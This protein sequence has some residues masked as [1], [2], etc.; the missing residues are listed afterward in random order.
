MQVHLRRKGDE[1]NFRAWLYR[2]AHN[3]AL[4]E[5]Q[6]A[7]HRLSDPLENAEGTSRAVDPAESPEQ[8]LLDKERSDRLRIAIGQ[9]PEVPRQCVVMR[10]QGLRFREIAEVLGLAL[11]TVAEHVQRGLQQVRETV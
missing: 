9:L 6:G 3:L 10:A 7:R 5:L 4:H 8:S 1:T 11:S 2:V